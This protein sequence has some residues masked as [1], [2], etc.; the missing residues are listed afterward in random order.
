MN[1]EI[2]QFF[3]K[4]LEIHFPPVQGSSLIGKQGT[5]LSIYN[6]YFLIYITNN[7]ASEASSIAMIYDFI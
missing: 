7:L 2:V 4:L 3:F 5:K 1:C 6:F